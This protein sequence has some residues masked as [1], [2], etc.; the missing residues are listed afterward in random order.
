[1]K[2]VVHHVNQGWTVAKALLG[3]ERAMIG[4]SIGR[5][6]GSGE[7]QLIA[8]ARKHLAKDGPIPDP[9]LRD[10]VAKNG[11]REAA[12]QLT[13]AR[14]QQTAAEK[15][16]PGPET[17]ITKVVATEMKQE[18]F[19][20]GM[21]ISGSEGLGW[22]GSEFDTEQLELTREWLRSRANTIEGGSSEI[23]LNIVAKRVLGLP[24]VG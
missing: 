22:E 24:D 18:R 19:E 4:Q 23:Q 9:V 14:I 12:F 10:A 5:Q 7:Q 16:S 3:H 15:G 21:R 6:P 17:S 8:L 1:V 13:L 20:L 2:N 11:M